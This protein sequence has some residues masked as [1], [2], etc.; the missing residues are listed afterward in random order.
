M[1]EIIPKHYIT[2]CDKGDLT[3]G[4]ILDI[5]HDDMLKQA[6]S[7]IKETAQ[8]CS[9]VGVLVATVV[10]AAAYTIPGGSEKGTPVLLRSPVFL[11]F[12]VMDIVALALSLASVVMFLSILT[13]PFELWDFHKSLPLKLNIGFAFLFGALTTTMMA[14]I[15]T[16]LL[17]INLPWTQ[18]SSSLIFGAAFFP[19]TIF[20]FLE[21]P[22]YNRLPFLVTKM[23]KKLMKVVPINKAIKSWFRETDKTKYP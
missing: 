15:A 19:L 2:H 18:W 20:A 6:Q 22:L 4:D 23:C 5:D 12:T 13:S 14:F 21:F 3:A 11:F 8:S 17:T 16:I 1:E 10:F 7:W 9:T